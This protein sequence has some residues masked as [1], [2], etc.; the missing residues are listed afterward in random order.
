VHVA[1]FLQA[2]IGAQ[3]T[4]SNKKVEKAIVK[5]KVLYKEETDWYPTKNRY[6]T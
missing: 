1:V 5:A 2:T 3:S 4:N 6:K